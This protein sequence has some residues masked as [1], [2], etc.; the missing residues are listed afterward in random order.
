MLLDIWFVSDSLMVQDY[1]STPIR[2]QY[3]HHLKPGRSSSYYRDSSPPDAE[4]TTSVSSVDM[5]TTPD[6]ER[7][8]RASYVHSRTNFTRGYV[9]PT[10]TNPDNGLAGPPKILRTKGRW[11]EDDESMPFDQRGDLADDAPDDEAAAVSPKRTLGKSYDDGR[12]G[13]SPRRAESPRYQ[14]LTPDTEIKTGSASFTHPTT[15]SPPSQDDSSISNTEALRK[16]H[17]QREE[18]DSHS[19]EAY[20]D[21]ED[22]GRAD[23][24]VP[25]REQL[26]P[27]SADDDDSL[28]DFEEQRHAARMTSLRRAGS[29]R[30]RSSRDEPSDDDSSLRNDY[31][32]VRGTSPTNLQERAQEAWKTRAKAQKSGVAT[33]K[34]DPAVSFGKGDTVHEFEVVPAYDEQTVETAGTNRS[35]VS[36]YSKSMESEYE[37]V[38]RDLFF[39]GSDSKTRPGRRKVKD[40]RAKRWLLGM[41]D[42][43]TQNTQEDSYTLNTLDDTVAEEETAMTRGT[44]R[45]T[46]TK[47]TFSTLAGED[48]TLESAPDTDTAEESLE[49]AP[50]K[51]SSSFPASAPSPVREKTKG[52]K[53]KSGKAKKDE[54]FQSTSTDDDPLGAVFR[55]FEGGISAVGAALGLSDDPEDERPLRKSTKQSTKEK[56]GRRLDDSQESRYSESVTGASERATIDTSA[57]TGTRPSPNAS[58]YAESP[59]HLNISEVTTEEEEAVPFDEMVGRALF[60]GEERPSN[61]APSAANPRVV[62]DDFVVRPKEKKTEGV[63]ENGPILLEKDPR[64]EELAVHTARSKHLLRGYVFDEN[65]GLNVVKDI[66]FFIVNLALPLGRKFFQGIG[67]VI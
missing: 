16:Y 67:V 37:D 20:D 3:Q 56:T 41:R 54:S 8:A 2:K 36:T 44:D 47:D 27:N 45:S 42:D 10:T 14:Y 29:S 65:S 58:G 24:D 60:G 11:E 26:R 7:R 40:Q 64:L 30:A 35:N 38:V 21:R 18:L 15:E 62:D 59:S 34:T 31:G 22:D 32:P 23:D 13:A 33:K 49:K 55:A 43:S 50:M 25:L 5:D 57:D 48:L 19:A 4:S 52:K 39:I 6:D 9:P 28:F 66:K 17:G 12:V 46:Y 53:E 63:S 1:T 61:K 51:K